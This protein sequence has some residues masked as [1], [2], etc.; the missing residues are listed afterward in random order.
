M[1]VSYF[2]I[3]SDEYEKCDIIKTVV[4]Y[5]LYIIY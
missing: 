1:L 2:E 3:G 5:V 4:I